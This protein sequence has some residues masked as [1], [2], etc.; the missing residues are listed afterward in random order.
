[1]GYAPAGT[2]TALLARL[3]CRFARNS[4]AHRSTRGAMCGSCPI[5]YGEPFYTA[6][7]QSLEV[8]NTAPDA[9]H[10]ILGRFDAWPGNTLLPTPTPLSTIPTEVLTA[11]GPFTL[12]I[13]STALFRGTVPN[14]PGRDII[15]NILESQP[16]ALRQ[17]DV[18]GNLLRDVQTSVRKSKFRSLTY[19]RSE[20]TRRT[21]VDTI[22]SAA[23][24]LAETAWDFAV[25]NAEEHNFSTQSNLG[26]TFVDANNNKTYLL[27]GPID[28]VLIGLD[29]SVVGHNL[30]QDPTVVIPQN[31]RQDPTAV[32][33]YVTPNHI[34]AAIRGTHRVCPIEVKT[35]TSADR[36][37]SLRQVI[38]ESLVVSKARYRDN[39]SPL[40][41]VLS[42]GQNWIFGIRR[43][44]KVYTVY[45]LWESQD[46]KDILKFS[47][48]LDLLRPPADLGSNEND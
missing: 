41:F 34:Y 14:E 42:D 36:A 13:V 48:N 32:P 5:N 3:A 1:M 7:L 40:P 16:Q 45:L 22:L 20:M 37:Q 39:P 47:R 23:A 28:Y 9:A 44:N 25:L 24:S 8:L 29:S 38:G 6:L 30:R 4:S 15:G 26:L 21:V 46:A 33:D 19:H 43:D 11:L 35:S 12:W 18:S 2:S 10:N 17:L 31:R 27:S